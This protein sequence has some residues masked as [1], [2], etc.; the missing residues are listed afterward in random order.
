MSRQTAEI[1][2][3]DY[4]TIT[5]Q[6][7]PECAP[8]TVANFVD[9]ANRGF[10]NGLT[11]HR[12]ISGFMMQGGDPAGNGTGGSDKEIRGEFRKNG[13]ANSRSH[14]RGAISMA[15]AMDPDSASSQFFICHQDAKFLDGSYAAFGFVTD[16]MEVVDK[17]CEQAKPVD[18]NGTIRR[19]EQPVIES[20]VIK[21]A[22]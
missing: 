4:G 18:G 16:G 1:T 21:T 22:D 14:T 6:L 8:I 12:I 13:V 2:I 19:K 3:R 17:V 5:V 10:Y 15:R 9:L 20:I 7:D 11:F